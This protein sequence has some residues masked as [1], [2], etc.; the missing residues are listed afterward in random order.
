MTEL[1][2][3]RIGVNAGQ[4]DTGVDVRGFEAPLLFGA[5][6]VPFQSGRQAAASPYS[7]FSNDRPAVVFRHAEVK[8]V[9]DGT[10]AR[11]GSVVIIM[12]HLNILQH[13][14]GVVG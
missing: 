11:G 12:V 3:T 4:P 7:T 10:G 6:V 1:S 9:C 2:G 14:D 5:Y 8:S 13:T